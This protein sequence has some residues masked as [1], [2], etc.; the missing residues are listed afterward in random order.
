LWRWFNKTVVEA[1][2]RMLSKLSRSH[3]A[4][5]MECHMAA[6]SGVISL[7]RSGVSSDGVHSMLISDFTKRIFFVLNGIDLQNEEESIEKLNSILKEIEQ[8]KEFILTDYKL[9]LELISLIN[10]VIIQCEYLKKKFYLYELYDFSI[11]YLLFFFQFSL[12]LLE[13]HPNDIAFI[14][15][16][17]KLLEFLE[18][19]AGTKLQNLIDKKDFKKL[20]I[21][22]EEHSFFLFEL[23]KKISPLIKQKTLSKYQFSNYDYAKIILDKTCGLFLNDNIDPAENFDGLKFILERGFDLLAS[24]EQF[25]DDDADLLIFLHIA[26]IKFLELKKDES[27]EKRIK[28]ILKIYREK[29]INLS[30]EIIKKK[31]LKLDLK[32]EPNT[33]LE[34]LV[35]Y[36][37]SV[38]ESVCF[39]VFLQ[40]HFKKIDYDLMKKI[41]TINTQYD[42]FISIEV[43]FRILNT[44][45]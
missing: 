36:F 42:R 22:N 43:F 25:S 16:F 27:I 41:E 37:I 9:S 18:K 29:N 35:Q 20:D 39:A 17:D 15:E 28:S 24:I 2:K 7:S 33:H 21:K 19:Y 31:I 32:N 13:T 4:C 38:E 10:N 14:D 11:N 30:A 5:P 45:F 23:L 34:K 3:G 26:H 12:K 40:V 44:I 6:L 1:R 8:K